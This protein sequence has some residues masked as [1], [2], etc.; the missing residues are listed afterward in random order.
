ETE[1]ED[2]SRQQAAARAQKSGDFDALRR[3]FL[4]TAS[5]AYGVTED[6]QVGA[7]IGYYRGTDFFAAERD[8]FGNVDVADADP[9]GPTDLWLQGKYRFIH[10]ELGSFA[11][12]A[13][14]KLP[15]GN[16]DQRLSNGEKLEPSSQP[17][18]GAFD[19]QAGLAWSRF[20]TPNLTADASAV[21]TL[22]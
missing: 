18:T 14:F 3:S 13:G 22:R 16:D 20:L 15:T 4:T 5:L 10:D 12:I 17:G 8:V 9:H 7:T 19:E 6:F 1:F 2:V 21:Y 11:L